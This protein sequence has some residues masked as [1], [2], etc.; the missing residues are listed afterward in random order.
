MSDKEKKVSIADQSAI[1]Y[2]GQKTDELKNKFKARSIPLEKDFSDLIDIA[3]VGRD[4]L[5][6]NPDQDG[7]LGTGLESEDG[8]DTFETGKKI[9]IKAGNGILVDSDGVAVKAGNGITVNSSGISINPSSI[10]PRGVI[11][12]FSGQ[13]A[14]TGWAFCDGSQETPDLR[15]R[16]VMCGETISET[17]Q[18]DN[19]AS[20]SENKKSFLQKTELT[21]VSVTVTVEETELTEEQIPSHCHLSGITFSTDSTGFNYGSSK[22][23]LERNK[24]N[25]LNNAENTPLEATQWSS[26]GA[27]QAQTSNAGENKGHKHN[28]SAESPGH[29]HHVDV[30]PPYYLLAFIMKL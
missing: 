28:A 30:I 19:R 20:G 1:S 22:I 11:V 14:P 9:Q 15:S 29:S 2:T 12:M 13:V 3:T 27:Y 16:F 6:Q 26:T 10:L 8:G 23:Q 25:S 7:K 21:G 24:Y 4:A 17:G 18:S 5:G